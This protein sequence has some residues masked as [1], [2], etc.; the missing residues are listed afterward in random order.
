M[1][2][3][4]DS[5]RSQTMSKAMK[6]R[7]TMSAGYR[8]FLTFCITI[9]I[10]TLLTV[11]YVAFVS[12]PEVGSRILAKMQGG[13]TNLVTDTENGTA[14]AV[15]GPDRRKGVYTV[16]VG[17]TD[18][19][20]TRTDTILLATVDTVNKTVNVLSIPRDTRA[21]MENG[22]VHKINAAHN[23]GMERMLTEI[24]NTVGFTPDN[25]VILD[26]EDFKEI[27]D[28]IDGVDV[29]VPMDMYYI[30]DDMVID[31]KEGQQT[32]NGEQ[33]LMLMRFRA[34]YPDADLGRIRAQQMVFQALA[35]KLM[36]AGTIW[37]VPKL[38]Q[39]FMDDIE[40]NYKLT[41]VVWLGLQCTHMDF[42]GFSVD[43]IPGHISGADYV[44]DVEEALQ[45]INEKYN[46]YTKP[47]TTLH[48]AQ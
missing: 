1:K 28:A 36:S 31:L 7:Y 5:N 4:S 46:P 44:V 21:Y 8:F 19:D 34:G 43:M 29:Y 25:Y 38:A 33:A 14:P 18:Y 24:T 23:K 40:T 47:I 42:E 37:N 3:A 26:Y 15:T 48:T 6:K 12:H 32:L 45:L 41:E 11:I 16:L 27:I 13:L 20:G 39:I 30:A 22:A 35:S 17:G 2:T 9:C 10:L